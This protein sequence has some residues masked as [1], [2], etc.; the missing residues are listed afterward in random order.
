MTDIEWKPMP[1]GLFGTPALT[2]E[3]G[4][5]C[6][7]AFLEDGLPSWEVRKKVQVKHG[8]QKEYQW[9]VIVNGTADSFEAAKAAAL[10]EAELVSKRK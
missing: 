1:P 3:L 5:L 4:G 2:A 7:S 10:F 6:I 9:H 8:N